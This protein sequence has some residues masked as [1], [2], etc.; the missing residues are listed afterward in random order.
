MGEL[1]I[2]YMD[3]R[4]GGH[5]SL[6]GVNVTWIDLDSLACTLHSLNQ[7]WTASR[8]VC[9]FCE[10]MVGSLSIATTAV[11]STKVAVV[12]S[13]EVGRS[14]VYIVGIIR[15]LGHCLGVHLH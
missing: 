1:R 5:V 12:D 8:S 13:G 6:R 11:S 2:V 14:T 4:G 10:A 9:S 15:A 7:S 3:W